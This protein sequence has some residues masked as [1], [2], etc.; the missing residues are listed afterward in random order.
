MRP[1]DFTAASP[2]EVEMVDGIF[3]YSPDPLPP[4]LESTHDLATK[5]G[6]AM[7]AL[8]KLSDL[9]T[10]L[11]SPEVILS[12]LVHREA[13]DSSSIETISQVTLSDL[14]RREAGEDVG[15]TAT[16]Q[17]DIAEAAGVTV[18]TLRKRYYDLRDSSKLTPE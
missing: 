8:G 16:E 9:E 3:T 15:T 18:A 2:G 13:A 7:Y 6:D 4:D 11:E 14:Y 12:P 1:E 10:W 17:A 5:N